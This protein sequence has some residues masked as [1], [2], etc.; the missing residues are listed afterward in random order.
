MTGLVRK[1]TLLVVLGVLAA[2]VAMAGIPDPATST[3][4]SYISLVG[5]KAGVADPY[6]AFTVTVN[7]A[8]GNPVQGCEVKIVF[9]ADLKIYDAMVGLAVDCVN[10]TVTAT[11]D[12]SGVA[13][14]T[15]TGATIN[16]NGV[17][18]GSGANGAT[19]YACEIA[20]GQ[21]T[22]CVFDESGAVGG[23]GVSAIDLG[24][25][26]GDFGKLGTIGYKGRSDF[27]HDGVISAIDLGYWVARFGAGNSASTCGTLCSY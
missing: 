13:S 14:F 17:A 6:G 27:S 16:S 2:S 4:P 9:A 23:L 25:W 26:V 18:A 21:A 12:A 3:V 7:D 8:A 15:I 22:V 5:C 11:S 20:L 1:A 24:G 10:R 19:V